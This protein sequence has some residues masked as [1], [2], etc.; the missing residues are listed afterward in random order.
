MEQL[1]QR[2]KLNFSEVPDPRGQ[3]APDV[4]RAATGDLGEYLTQAEADGLYEPLGGGGGGS[5]TFELDDGTA[6]AD[7]V[8]S[9]DEGGA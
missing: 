7:G 3:G 9:F 8:F 6:T 1:R 4:P 5:G 2:I